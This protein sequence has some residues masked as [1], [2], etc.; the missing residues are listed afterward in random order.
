MQVQST[1]WFASEIRLSFNHHKVMFTN[2]LSAIYNSLTMKE[3]KYRS[4]ECLS[5]NT[6]IFKS[7]FERQDYNKR[8]SVQDYQ[9]VTR[10]Y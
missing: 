9:N 3:N 5:A 2:N 8:Q 7:F 4:I 1:Y 6:F 10:N